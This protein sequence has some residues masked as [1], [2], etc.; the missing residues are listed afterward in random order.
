MTRYLIDTNL[1][2]Y[3]HDGRDPRR[4]AR[5]IEVVRTLRPSDAVLSSQVL[6]E[7][8]SVLLTKLQPR[9]APEVVASQVERLH[10]RFTVHPVTTAVVIEALR[11][12]E[13]HRLPYWDAQL[14]AT[15][16]L[17]QVRV[18]LSEDTRPGALD[19]VS[20]LDPLDENVDL[21]SL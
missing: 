14:W 17:H 18:I 5:A 20:W 16:R 19:G 21:A 4:Q 9:L 12:V 6:G 1:L 15:A 3:V 7:L 8:S 11:G 2:I 13:A 10:D